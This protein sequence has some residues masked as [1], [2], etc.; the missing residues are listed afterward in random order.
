MSNGSVIILPALPPAGNTLTL[1]GAAF[2][3]LLQWEPRVAEAYTVVA[4]GGRLKRARLLKLTETAAELLVFEDMSS[5]LSRLEVVLLQALPEKERMEQVIQKTTE[6]GVSAI[7]PF[8]SEKSTSLDERDS[9]QKKSGRW[10]AVAL[11]AAR[12]CRRESLVELLPYRSFFEAI[13]AAG[14][15]DLKLVLSEKPGPR[16]LK[17]VLTGFKGRTPRRVSVMA[18]PEGGLTDEEVKKAEASGFIPVSLGKR[19][20]RTETASIISVG[21]IRYELEE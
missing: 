18:G 8:K 13:E 11:K 3:A 10:A 16:M 20:L 6:L 7:V 19:I 14:G 15:S 21:L 2:D 9:K 17:E 12:Q 4:P 5:T 1:E